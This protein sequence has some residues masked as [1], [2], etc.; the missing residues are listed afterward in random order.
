MGLAGDVRAGRYVRP[1]GLSKETA[2]AV[3][4]AV[5]EVGDLVPLVNATAVHAA[6]AAGTECS[7]RSPPPSDPAEPR[8]RVPPRRMWIV[9]STSPAVPARS[10]RR[11][12]HHYGD[13][14]PGRHEPRGLLFGE[15]TG[16]VWVPQHA[17]GDAEMGTT[18]QTF[19]LHADGLARHGDESAT[20]GE[21]R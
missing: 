5:A 16:R 7:R 15:R 2:E 1:A 10:R 11:P 9:D 6:Q 13:C 4:E 19:H 20:R 8:V 14:C 17:R 21:A 12:V 18:R 3:G